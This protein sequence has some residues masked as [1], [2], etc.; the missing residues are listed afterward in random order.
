MLSY[1][2]TKDK[3][4]QDKP[5]DHPAISSTNGTKNKAWWRRMLGQ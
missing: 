1:D 5:E 3:Y 2:L 4:N